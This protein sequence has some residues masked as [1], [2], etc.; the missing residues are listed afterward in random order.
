MLLAP[1][2]Q[3]VMPS[4]PDNLGWKFTEPAT[5]I[6]F[7]SMALN[8]IAIRVHKHRVAMKIPEP[9]NWRDVFLDELCRQ[10]GYECE[11]NRFAIGYEPEHVIQ[12]RALWNELHA[13]SRVDNL[14]EAMQIWF[15]AWVARI[16]RWSGCTCREGLII[17]LNQRHPDYSSRQAF[18]SFCVELHSDISES[19][20]KPRWVV[21]GELEATPK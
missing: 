6:V 18:F 8:E 20:G 9:H 15:S 21:T 1:T 4:S 13:F 3:S 11:P 10:G 7:R 5:G 2:V 14:P 19:I 16:P 17:A 12:G